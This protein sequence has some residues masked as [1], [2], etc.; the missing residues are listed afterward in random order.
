MTCSLQQDRFWG[1]LRALPYP[2][3]VTNISRVLPVLALDNI[4]MAQSLGLVYANPPVQAG[5]VNLSLSLPGSLCF[6]F[7]TQSADPCGNRTGLPDPCINLANTTL[8]D[9][10]YANYLH[11]ASSYSGKVSGT[12]VEYNSTT[13]PMYNP[14]AHGPDFQSYDSNRELI[15]CWDTVDPLGPW[16]RPC[17]SSQVRTPV[18]WGFYI[19]RAKLYFGGLKPFADGLYNDSCIDGQNVTYPMVSSRLYPHDPESLLVPSI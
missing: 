1:I 13:I 14:F 7:L 18:Q 10:L 9:V 5:T 6:Q 11:V 12:L 8:G 16:F 15:R 2:V 3:P 17:T 4:S 19:H